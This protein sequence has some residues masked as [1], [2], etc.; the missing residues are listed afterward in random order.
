MFPIACALP[1]AS[2]FAEHSVST[3]LVVEDEAFVCELAAEALLDHDPAEA[4]R[5]LVAVRTTAH[6]ALVEMRRLLGV[7]R[8]DEAV[9][10][11][12]PTLER[13]PALVEDARA[14][15]RQAEDGRPASALV[16]AGGLIGELGLFVAVQRVSTALARE[17]S[18]VMRIRRSV[19]R[20]VLAESPAS[21]EAMAGAIA[22][23]LQDLAAELASVQGVLDAIEGP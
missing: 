15:G 21:A 19:M 13:V 7:L 16:E 17:P 6:E 18:Q 5:H 8:Q 14:P 23:R 11:P 3:V 4:R 9:Y 12:Q 22:D 2:N 10:Q 1:H 20:R